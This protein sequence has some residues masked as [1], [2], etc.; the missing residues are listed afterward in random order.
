MGMPPT[1]KKNNRVRLAKTRKHSLSKGSFTYLSL[2]QRVWDKGVLTN[3]FHLFKN[4]LLYIL[5]YMNVHKLKR[6]N[7]YIYISPENLKTQKIK[8]N[9]FLGIMKKFINITSRIPNNIRPIE[10]SRNYRDF[11]ILDS[12]LEALTAP[13]NKL[14]NIVY[15]VRKGKRQLLND[16][17]IISALKEKY[18]ETYNI[19]I[20]DFD[21]KSF[22]EQI[23]IMNGCI[24]FIGAHGAGFTN[25]FFMA[26]GANLL[27]FF[28]ESFY[29]PC[30][31]KI[32]KRK[33][34]NHHYLH[35]KSTTVPPI[36]LETYLKKQHTP[37]YRNSEL[38]NSLRD[39]SFSIDTKLVMEKLSKILP[40]SAEVKYP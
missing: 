7:T 36:T 35:G 10:I 33:H 32:C 6:K 11:K 38:R 2:S 15:V 23:D 26:P 31:E 24:L 21:G 29:T 8:G 4:G 13:Q 34:I 22:Q 39:T 18:N 30:Y 9:I 19:I 27:E 40:A 37:E 5:T 20:V 1:H 3:Y 28:P 17:E 12:K 16:K 25:V 14:R